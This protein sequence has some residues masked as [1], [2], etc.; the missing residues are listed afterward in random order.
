[1]LYF[2]IL[3]RSI[4]K[5]LVYT[6]T[7]ILGLSIALSFLFL[8]SV[9]LI[10]EYTFDQSYPKS[11][12]IHRL[13]LKG[14]DSTQDM[15]NHSF[16]FSENFEAQYPAIESV[17]RTYNNPYLSR[18]I[19][20]KDNWEQAYD[21]S[22]FWYVESGFLNMFDV[23][24]VLGSFSMFDVPGT[25]IINESIREKFF[26]EKNP[27]GQKILIENKELEVIGVF[28]DFAS[29]SSLNPRFIFS[30]E[31]L[32]SEN[33]KIFESS[34]YIMFEVFASLVQDTDVQELNSQLT[35]S[36]NRTERFNGSNQ[37]AMERLE[38]YHFSEGTVNLAYKAK[39]DKQ[40]VVW[41]AVISVCLL[42]VAMA[43]FG[44][45]S[46]AI[47]LGRSKEIA[48]QKVI[49][50]R[51]SQ[52]IWNSLGQSLLLS[53]I[54]F[55]VALV[56]IE[57]LMPVYG[58][59][60][61]RELS[62]ST[63]GL[64]LFI[65]LFAFTGVIGILAGLYP[66]FVI[67]NFKV[68]N[69]SN[70]SGGV[71]KSRSFIR[72]AL[73]SFQFLI[74]FSLIST[75]LFMNRQLSFMLEKDP[76]YDFQNTLV[77][78]SNWFQGGDE[79][80]IQTFKDR[81]IAMPEIEGIA[82][83]DNH[84]M[85]VIG[86]ND[87]EIAGFNE[88]WEKTKVLKIGIDCRF[89]DFYNISHSFDDEIISL[90]CSDSKVGLLNSMALSTLEN[91]PIGK[92]IPEFYGPGK[93]GYI[94][95][96]GAVADI[97][98]SSVRQEVSSM[99][100]RP[101]A[102]SNGRAHYSIRYSKNT[103]V[104][105]LI[106]KLQDM[107]WGEEPMEPFVLR[108][109]SEEHERLYSS[110]LKMM[111]M[112]GILG[113]GVCIIAFAGVFAIS[114]FYGRERLKEISIRKILGAGVYQLFGLQNRIFIVLMLISFLIAIPIVVLVVDSWFS[115]FAYRTNQPWWLFLIAAVIMILST[116]L[117]SAWYSMKVAKVNP[118]D[119]LRDS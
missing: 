32:K 64:E 112:T 58:Q 79:A 118:A 21:E 101:L 106:L 99:L 16:K 65:I 71:S 25:V 90:F 11:E 8:T 73:L 87:L 66:S 37:L 26:K 15:D 4:K 81:L 12:S 61:Q 82:L 114:I 6:W 92:R 2:R 95:Q 40:L 56:F 113:I 78:R 23:Q 115:Q 52:L 55:V 31:T 53:L 116:I 54:A 44:N 30:M 20:V 63:I 14:A 111:S 7:N 67:S 36:L 38:D 68:S 60:V 102:H 39:M 22:D 69:L 100:F 46:L 117:S 85:T 72:R 91:E 35:E 33:K 86:V 70:S 94:V 62:G 13:V 57:L 98:F 104:S 18:L 51:K 27:I 108:N 9:Y 77:L 93:P 109:L 19:R 76:G 84:P 48:I 110:E 49:G 47:A 24:P 88:G 28:K 41:L 83:S 97:N 119:V 74:A 42:A 29:N 96:D 34:G 5:N 75:V 50:A 3:F 45:I 43:N 103:N 80:K 105:E 89:L 1:M 59:F 107:W 10:H 17:V